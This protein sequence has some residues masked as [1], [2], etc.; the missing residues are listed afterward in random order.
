[1]NVP[2]P[3]FFAGAQGLGEDSAA[4]PPPQM[5]RPDPWAHYRGL[6][7]DAPL[8]RV[9]DTARDKQAFITLGPNCRDKF[10]AGLAEEFG[11]KT[12]VFWPPCAGDDQ[13]EVIRQADYAW[14][15]AHGKPALGAA[16]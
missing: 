13:Y 4:A 1:V 3:D 7:G 5:P 15:E 9:I 8:V 14:G 12:T 6:V 2:E 10:V 16:P 11:K